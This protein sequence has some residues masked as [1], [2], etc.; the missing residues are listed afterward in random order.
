MEPILILQTNM[1]DGF[2]SSLVYDDL[3][4]FAVMLGQCFQAKCTLGDL[5]HEELWGRHLRRQ[6]ECV[7]N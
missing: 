6:L 3:A 2:V 4:C 7:V 5:E 1:K